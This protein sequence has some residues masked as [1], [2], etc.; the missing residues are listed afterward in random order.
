MDRLSLSFVLHQ[1]N[2]IQ[3]T[4]LNCEVNIITLILTLQQFFNIL[5]VHFI[6]I[7]FRNSS[8]LQGLI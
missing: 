5:A 7:L 1:N 6:V 4:E 8:L 2:G 3:N